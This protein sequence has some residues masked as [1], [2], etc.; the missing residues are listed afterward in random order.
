[1]QPEKQGM[2]MSDFYLKRKGVVFYH[3]ETTIVRKSITTITFQ[4]YI[5]N[6]ESLS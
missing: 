6:E 1:M 5:V 3:F 4:F 2:G